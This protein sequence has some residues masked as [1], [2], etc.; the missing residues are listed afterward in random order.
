[1]S[2]S[3]DREIRERLGRLGANAL[4]PFIRLGS[5]NSMSETLVWRPIDTAPRDRR[6]LL[7]D[8][9]NVH[10]GE[11]TGWGGEIKAEWEIEYRDKAPF[12]EPT[13]WMPIEPPKAEKAP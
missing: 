8:G 11:W 13:Y 5:E 4:P 10:I 3:R 2:E 1:M 9:V 7:S 6:V 12:Y